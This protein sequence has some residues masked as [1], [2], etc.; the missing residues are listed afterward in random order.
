M[1]IAARSTSVVGSPTMRLLKYSCKNEPMTAAKDQ[2]ALRSEAL[3]KLQGQP[4]FI[5]LMPSY[6]HGKPVSERP[7]W[8]ASTG[9]G[10]IR[11]CEAAQHLSETQRIWLN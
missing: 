5:S 3:S 9:C 11:V 2:S 6:K 8:S 10:S 4:Y 7:P 1:I